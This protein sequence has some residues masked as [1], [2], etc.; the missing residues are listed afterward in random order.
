[1]RLKATPEDFLVREA[2]GLRIRK[3]P[4][5]YRVYMLEKQ[6][7]NTV[8]ALVR[9]AKEKRVPYERFAYGGKKDR[10]AHTFQYVTVQHPADLSLTAKGY[11]LKAMGYAPEPMGPSLIVANHFELTVRELTEPE[12]AR[13][14]ANAGRLQEQGVPNYFDDQRFG[15]LDKERGF[16]AEK[17]VQ[18]RWEEALNLALTAIYPE[19]HSEAKQRKRAMRERWG[20]WAACRELARTGL[21][22]RSFDL[23]MAKPDAFREALAT[24]PKETAAMWLSTYQSFLWNETLRR[25]L[26]RRGLGGEAVPGAAGPYL[27]LAP[28]AS[29]PPDLIIP[30]PGRGMRFPDPE[31][32]EVLEEVLRERRLRPAALEGEVLPGFSFRASPRPALLAPQGLRLEPS[33][34]DDRYP[35][36]L[37]L[38]VRFTL[39]RGSYATMI[40]KGLAGA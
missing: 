19:E 38:P 12:A 5:P 13:I 26:E 7:W 30:L 32:G 17:M 6:D 11:S 34:P 28:G 4:A 29:L 1:M 25:L 24:A 37:K 15:N 31:S 35:G 18:G 9:I 36:K 39:P 22:Q 20:D 21:E 23:L 33:E 40:I 3:Q 27:L 8:D 10:H 2:T 16:I 14:A